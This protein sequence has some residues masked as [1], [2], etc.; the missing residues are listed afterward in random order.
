M[1]PGPIYRS[2]F[3]FLDSWL[4]AQSLLRSIQIEPEARKPGIRDASG[5]PA[6]RQS[7]TLAATNE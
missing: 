5:S 6:P 3:G 2:P 7:L 1:T 4:Q